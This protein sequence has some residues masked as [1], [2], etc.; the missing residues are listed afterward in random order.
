MCSDNFEPS[1]CLFV[2]QQ[3][4]FRSIH[5]CEIALY[6]ILDMWKVSSSPKKVN[7]ALFIVF[8]KAFNINNSRLLIFEIVSLLL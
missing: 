5:F 4:G 8:K 3:H 2:D 6:S 7:L 1:K